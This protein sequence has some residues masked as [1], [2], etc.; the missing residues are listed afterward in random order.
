MRRG[1]RQGGEIAL[2]LTCVLTVTAV[3]KDKKYQSQSQIN[4]SIDRISLYK[5]WSFHFFLKEYLKPIAANVQSV[6]GM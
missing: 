4:Y 6:I 3:S 5:L 2:P 1:K